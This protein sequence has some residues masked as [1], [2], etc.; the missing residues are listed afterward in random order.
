MAFKFGLVV[1]GFLKAPTLL[2]ASFDDLNF[3]CM[4]RLLVFVFNIHSAPSLKKSFRNLC[5]IS[6]VALINASVI[7]GSEVE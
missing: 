7:A 5:P 6:L 3:S 2:Q 4:L 1:K